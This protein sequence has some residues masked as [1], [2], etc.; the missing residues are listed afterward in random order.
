MM[1][2]L[3][4]IVNWI[5]LN[6]VS[7]LGIAQA[8]VKFVKEVLT[9]IVNILF[10]IIPNAKFQAIVMAVRNVVN[11]IDEWIEKIKSWI[12]PVVA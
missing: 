4:K 6:I 12:L 5:R 2:F 8:V 9:A 11:K 1:G 10:P 7:V 3:K